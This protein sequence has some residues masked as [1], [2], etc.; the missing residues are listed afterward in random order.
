MASS[1][2]PQTHTTVL[3]THLHV[4]DLE[5]VPGPSSCSFTSVACLQY[6]SFEVRPLVPCILLQELLQTMKRLKYH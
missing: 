6:A 4:K 5:I 3:P 2:H 1:P